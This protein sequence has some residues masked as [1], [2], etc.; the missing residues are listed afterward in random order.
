MIAIILILVAIGLALYLSKKIA[1]PIIHINE[2][3]KVL[4]TGKYDVGFKGKGYLEV[5]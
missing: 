3:A 1:T 4:A 2:R 5:E